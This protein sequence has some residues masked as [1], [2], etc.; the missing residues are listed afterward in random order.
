MEDTPE[1]TPELPFRSRTMSLVLESG[2]GS[3]DMEREA[4][5]YAP[6]QEAS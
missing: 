5:R 6:A 4:A 1:T 2:E 3:P